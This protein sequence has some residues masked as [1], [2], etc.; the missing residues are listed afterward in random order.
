MILLD[1]SPVAIAN[2]MI[3]M[4][5]PNKREYMEGKQL[6]ADL[7][8]HMILNSI[9][10]YNVKFRRQYGEMIIC[11]DDTNYW[12]K[13]VFPYY[14]AKRKKEQ[15]KSSI[16]WAEVFRVLNI[17][18]E[19]L[20]EF[21]P[22]KVLQVEEAEADDIIGALAKAYG[23]YTDVLIISGDKDFQQLQKY[24]KVA[25]YA[26]VKKAFLKCANPEKFLKEQIICGDD[27]DG[28]PNFLSDDDAIINE[29]KRQK[30]VSKKKLAQ[31]LEWP[32][33]EIIN[34]NSQLA[35]NWERNENMIDLDKV[36]EQYTIDVMKQ[37]A[38]PPKGNKTTLM[39]LM[40][41]RG[42]VVLLDSIQD[43]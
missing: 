35:K 31:W 27:G 23:Q 12:R 11:C 42:M 34:Q 5:G 40:M 20:K 13:R 14:K 4:N 30:P 17:V 7:V 37:Y 8:R 19:E 9:R 10:S 36:P 15:D 1:F 6:S 2:L 33:W 22:Y 24:P 39:N 38:N 18:R 29:D 16:N 26:P 41:N 3:E 25:Q 32:T 43:F 21:G 28:V